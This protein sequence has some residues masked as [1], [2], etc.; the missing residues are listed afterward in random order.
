MASR[1]FELPVLFLG[2]TYPRHPA[3]PSLYQCRPWVQKGGTSLHLRSQ[4]RLTQLT[5]I[6]ATKIRDFTASKLLES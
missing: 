5:V 2:Q 1:L 6:L 3:Q 4:H